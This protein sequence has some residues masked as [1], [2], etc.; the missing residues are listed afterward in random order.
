MIPIVVV[1]ERNDIIVVGV[2]GQVGAGLAERVS[3]NGVIGR[4][5]EAVE[6][7]NLKGRGTFS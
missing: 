4:I 3:P 2:G 1:F 5:D 6:V 7:D